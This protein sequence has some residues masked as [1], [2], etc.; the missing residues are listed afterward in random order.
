[1]FPRTPLA[2]TTGGTT[3]ATESNFICSNKTDP[4]ACRVFLRPVNH[5]KPVIH[6][7]LTCSRLATPLG[8]N[9]RMLI[10]SIESTPFRIPQE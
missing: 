7:K 4:A 3:T 8:R 9:P 1:L 5:F 2:V 6:S 10:E